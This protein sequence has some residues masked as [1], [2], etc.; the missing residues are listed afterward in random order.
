MFQAMQNNPELMRQMMQGSPLAQNPQML[1]Q[2]M[3]VCM[4]NHCTSNAH[5]LAYMYM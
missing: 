3:Q 4:D 1:A 5:T 2:M